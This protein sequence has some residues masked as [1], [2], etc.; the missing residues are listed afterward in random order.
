M[1]GSSMKEIRT[2]FTCKGGEIAI[3]TSVILLIFMAL[4]ALSISF[5]SVFCKIQVQNSF[6]HEIAR[7]AEI[8]GRTGGEVSDEVARMQAVMNFD[9]EVDWQA[10]YMD[11]ANDKIQIGSEFTVTVTSK[12]S[13]GIGGIVKIDVPITSK[14]TGRSEYYWK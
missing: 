4:F 6:A 7:Y 1:Q 8:K 3:T 13:M 9:T 12:A 5:F 10:D 2:K 11:S 14:A